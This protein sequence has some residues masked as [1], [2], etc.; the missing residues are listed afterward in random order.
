MG[1][2]RCSNLVSRGEGTEAYGSSYSLGLY[3]MGGGHK[4][5]GDHL[6]PRP[7]S[8]LLLITRCCAY[9]RISRLLYTE[10]RPLAPRCHNLSLAKYETGIEGVRPSS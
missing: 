4:T 8:D 5:V 1:A 9:S 6:T 7:R 3:L 2:V 10:R